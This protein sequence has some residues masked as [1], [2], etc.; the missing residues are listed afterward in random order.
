MTYEE[1]LPPEED[2]ASVML[3]EEDL[4]LSQLDLLLSQ[5]ETQLYPAAQVL[6]E[7]PAASGP[8][9]PDDSPCE[10]CAL[11]DNDG[12]MLLCDKS[13]CGYHTSCLNPPLSAVPEGPWKCAACTAIEAT[14]DACM[15]F[16][17]VPSSL[18][19]QAT[20][21]SGLDCIGHYGIQKILH[22][23]TT[24]FW[25]RGMTEQVKEV[26]KDCRDCQLIQVSL[27]EPK[28]LHSAAL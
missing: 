6:P 24:R 12:E 8:S 20:A 14:V 11:S 13:V 18:T 1:F 16:P 4:L 27:N 26:L 25:W 5:L 23:L 22:M 7:L 19:A 15:H 3:S 17:L 9:V 28:E 21:D 10:I 2:N